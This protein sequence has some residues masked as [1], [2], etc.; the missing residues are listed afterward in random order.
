LAHT[1]ARGANRLQGAGRYAEAAEV[2]RRAQ[3]QF[4]RLA[5]KEPTKRDYLEWLAGEHFRFGIIQALAGQPVESEK[6][7]RQAEAHYEKLAGEGADRHDFL[8]AQASTRHNIAVQLRCQNRMDDAES[9][10]R[11]SLKLYS[12]LPSDFQKKVSY[13]NNVGIT[14]NNLA[15]LLT[16]PTCKER[17]FDDAVVF[18]KQAV[19][20]T[21]T[22]GHYWN[23]LG[24]AQYRAGNWKDAAVAIEKSMTLRN[25]GD[26]V[27]LFFMAMIRH[28][29]NDTEMA[30]KWLDKAFAWSKTH[31][32]KNEELVR[33]RV[34]AE[35]LMGIEG[36][37]D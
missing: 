7:Y 1:L 30:R 12:Q 11:Q 36:K 31:G 15:R 34:E 16:T 13:C 17:R 3:R 20:S 29:L 22:A 19:E 33:Y 28:Q 37:G 32:P 14:S 23:T 35:E 10:F 8:F 18:A 26:G 27:D 24:I 9:G 5:E 25:G 6:A 2:C 21:P 4:T